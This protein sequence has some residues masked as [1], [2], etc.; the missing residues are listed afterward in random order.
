LIDAEEK[1]KTK[2]LKKYSWPEIDVEE[3]MFNQT[4]L[5]AYK[6]ILEF[7]NLLKEN[8]FEK[9]INAFDKVFNS[10]YKNANKR[11]KVAEW[12]D[13]LFEIGAGLDLIPNILDFKADKK[14]INSSD[15]EVTFSW[16]QSKGNKTYINEIL[17]NGL[18]HKLSFK[19]STNV[20]LKIVNEFGVS[21][22]EINIQANKI[23]PTVTFFKSD[24]LERIDLTPV[25][26]SWETNHTKK[27]RISEIND[28]LETSGTHEIDPR[29]NKTII[30]TAIGNF[31]EEV[32]AKVAIKVCSPKIV[33]FKYEINIEKGIDNIDLNW[34]TEN[35]NQVKISPRIGP[36]DINGQTSIGIVEKTEFTL[37][38]G[39]Y[40][41]T[42]EKVIQTQP[43]PIPLIKTMLIPT[44]SFNQNIEFEKDAFKIPDNILTD[45]NINFNNEI[46]F[47]Q[48]PIDFVQFVINEKTKEQIVVEKKTINL[49]EN[50][51]N[52]VMKN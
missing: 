37:T 2:Y 10:G 15:D 23:E 48:K 31:D 19:D 38:A 16:K 44:P 28:A 32:N 29:A 14:I 9:L 1:T 18:N 50:L 39:G 51:Y 34:K 8:G 35:S 46:N 22:K 45:L 40:F 49:F 17:V 25:I 3:N 42:V 27:V 5:T 43:F 24:I 21:S 12:Y 26:L 11:V 52:K 30:L 20:K 13:I 6:S 33:E 47:N 4:N 36:V 41:N 7:Y